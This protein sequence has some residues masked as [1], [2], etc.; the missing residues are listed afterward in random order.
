MNPNLFTDEFRN[1]KYLKSSPEHVASYK[2]VQ[3]HLQRVPDHNW[4]C[5]I[6]FV[7]QLLDLSNETVYLIEPGLLYSA[8]HDKHIYDW[9]D[10]KLHEIIHPILY[11]G[12]LLIPE[13]GVRAT[14]DDIPEIEDRKNNYNYCLVSEAYINEAKDRT[15]T[16]FSTSFQAYTLDEN[17]I[18][19]D[20][21][22]TY[23]AMFYD[24]QWAQKYQRAVTTYLR[25]NN[26]A[27]SAISRLF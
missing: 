10:A 16:T 25:T 15:R 19:P 18:V 3:E 12:R 21:Y 13:D 20:S 17:P 14:I 9:E 2:D 1:F 23:A 27:V 8:T 22:V 6:Q 26:N 5:Q 4:E 24:K 11:K 7:E